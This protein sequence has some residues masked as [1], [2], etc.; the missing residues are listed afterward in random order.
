MSTTSAFWSS[1]A[2][3]RAPRDDDA[4]RNEPGG[5]LYVSGF[6]GAPFEIG[7][8]GSLAVGTLLRP[9]FFFLRLALAFLHLALPAQPSAAAEVS[10]RFLCPAGD[11]VHQVRLDLFRP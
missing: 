4:R 9:L 8:L 6:S 3:P 7:G 2:S 11:R 1:C 10:G 5:G